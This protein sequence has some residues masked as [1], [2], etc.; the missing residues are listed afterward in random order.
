MILA[1]SRAEHGHRRPPR[2]RAPGTP[3]GGRRRACPCGAGRDRCVDSP[4][5]AAAKKATGTVPIVGVS[6]GDPVRMGWVTSLARPGGNVT[7]AGQSPHGLDGKW[8]E[9]L[10]EIVPKISRVA[11]LWNPAN[12][13]MATMCERSAW[14][15]APRARSSSSTRGHP[16]DVDTAFVEMSKWRSGGLLVIPDAMFWTYRAEIVDLAAK[17]RLP[18]VLLEYRVSQTLAAL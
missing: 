14:R 15:L 16:R 12:L 3:S 2:G 13:D 11:V 7:G 4:A 5:V 8:L 18:A 10:K 1:G 9:V 17:S 6:M